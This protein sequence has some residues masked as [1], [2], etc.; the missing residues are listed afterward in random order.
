MTSPF[1]ELIPDLVGKVG[2]TLSSVKDGSVDLVVDDVGVSDQCRQDKAGCIARG[3]VNL[4]E[5]SRKLMRRHEAKCD[6][7]HTFQGAER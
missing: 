1:G 4:A 7:I 3:H 5:A 2:L 6:I